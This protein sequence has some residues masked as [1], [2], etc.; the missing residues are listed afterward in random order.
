[1]YS[2]YNNVNIFELIGIASRNNNIGATKD[3]YIQYCFMARPSN[4]EATHQNVISFRVK[5]FPAT[6]PAAISIDYQ[7]RVHVRA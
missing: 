2:D 4:Y 7:L 5:I 1:M 3:F 6:P